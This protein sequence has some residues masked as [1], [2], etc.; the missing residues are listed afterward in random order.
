M[1]KA[2]NW[3]CHADV[4]FVWTERKYTRHS[5]S[6][7][8]GKRLKIP[9]ERSKLLLQSRKDE[10]DP[11]RFIGPRL[12]GSYSGNTDLLSNSFPQT[13]T[14]ACSPKA[15]LLL[16]LLASAADGG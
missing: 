11:L 13:N 6:R 5:K 12:T 7:K 4:W 15:N 3:R 8:E 1:V 14:S 2:G 10:V 16:Y 9:R